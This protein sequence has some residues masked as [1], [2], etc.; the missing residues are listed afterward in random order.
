MTAIKKAGSLRLFGL[1]ALSGLILFNP[2][3]AGAQL[4]GI[5]QPA[6]GTTTPPTNQ[7]L[8]GRI[9]SDI[10]PA[11]QLMSQG[12]YSE[13]ED[14]FRELLVNNP[15]D[16]AATVGLGT[17]LAKQFKLDGADDMLDRVLKSDPNNA[18]AFAGKAN[19]ILNRL[20]SSSGTIRDSRDSYLRQ[21]EDY[22]RRATALAPASGE[23]HFTLGQVYKEQGR[24]DDAATE[25]RTA[26][27]LDP[28]HSQAL[29]TLGSI[30][31][32]QGSLAEAA[33]NFKRAINISS[34]NSTAHYGLGAVYL[35]QGQIDDA[36]KELNTS[37]YQFP[38]SWPVRM[39]LGDA[40]AQQGNQVAAIK[41]YQLSILIKPENAQPY[42]RI[43]DIRESRSD[44]EL[45]LADLRS[46]LSQIPYDLDLRQRIAE[47]CLKLEKAD[48]AIKG[49][50]TILQMSPN[51]PQAVKGLSQGLY[52]KAQ[53]AAVGALLASNDYE[54]ALKSL[55]EAIKLSPDDMELRLAQAKLMSLAGAKPDLSKMGEPQ[56]N[57]ERLA[58]A[59]ALMAQGEF[60]KATDMMKSV[61]G[62]VNDPKQAFAVA[63]VALLNKDLDDAEAAYKKALSLSGAPDRAQRGLD[64]VARLRKAS[65][66]DVRVADE[67]FKKNQLDGA[68]DRYRHAVSTNPTLPDARLGLARSLEKMQKATSSMLSESA[69]QYQNYMTLNPNQPSKEAEKMRQNIA[70]L[71]DKAAKLAEKET[72]TRR[73]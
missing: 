30:K 1:L 52:L 12:R 72:K 32:D 55:D 45:A 42:L 16:I 14:M 44:L 20:Q 37:L 10:V 70:K 9:K 27:S 23:A 57:G 60:Q 15:A 50:R 41:E 35:K 40:Y 33:E 31:L 3:T 69:M 36:I 56:N 68:I 24:I 5:T 71:R 64:E 7:I 66:E 22:A 21:A 61:V 25:L 4:P 43:A 17:A 54:A 47:I 59:E 11:E 6:T 46:G 51:N 2:T 73:S 67:L 49:F 18:L 34:S 58:Y 38:N 26:V 65:L 8:T 29:S 13:A 63:D 53:K 19:V 62:T 39:A 48:D 28:Q